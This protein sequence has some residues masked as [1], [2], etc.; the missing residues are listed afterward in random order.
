MTSPEPQGFTSP[1]PDPVNGP[2]VYAANKA[3]ANG[4]TLVLDSV[5]NFSVVAQYGQRVD[6]AA[7]GTDFTTFDMSGI[8][9]EFV[10]EGALKPV[11]NG[12]QSALHM[13]KR[14]W[15]LIL[16]FTN[17]A[18]R[19]NYNGVV[20]Q[21]RRAAAG[22]LA[23]AIDNLALVG[24]TGTGGQAG[25][26]ATTKEVELGSAARAD[27]GLFA[28]YNEA[29]RLLVADGKK[30]T[31]FLQ[32]DIVEP[33]LN[34]AVDLNGRPLWIDSPLTIDQNAVTRQGRL[35]G[36][37][38]YQVADLAH[39]GIVGYAGDFR[40]IRWGTLTALTEDV[41]TT[42]TVQ[43]ATGEQVSAYQQNLTLFRYEAEVGVLIPDPEAFVKLMDED[44]NS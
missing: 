24:M 12:T 21:A 32:D 10:G 16:P 44:P 1:A 43:L 2:T 13:S 33:L 14:K 11:Q 40:S 29:L 5:R 15:A 37:P 28:D 41:N 9:G 26:D 34:G 27:G 36:R 6:L 31:G 35:L 4:G 7:G 30:L 23:R 22:A 3:V 25:I 39:D 19:E 8:T 17:E 20:T 18:V 42:A 38:A